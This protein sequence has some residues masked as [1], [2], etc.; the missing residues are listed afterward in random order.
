[1]DE[2]SKKKI[3]PLWFI[4]PLSIIA[5]GFLCYVP[6]WINSAYLKGGEYQTVWNGSEF[7]AFY[8][9][10]L[11]ALGA[12]FL[13]ALSIWQNKQMQKTNEEAQKRLEDINKNANEITIINKFVERENR[14]IENLSKACDNFARLCL[15]T[16]VAK[17][18]SENKDLDYSISQ[19]RIQI[20]NEHQC[21]GRE[22]SVDLLNQKNGVELLAKA[23][24]LYDENNKFFERLLSEGESILDDENAYND[25]S[26]SYSEFIII[27]DDY[28]VAAQENINSVLLGEI[29]LSELRLTHH[30]GME[31]KNG[32]DEDAE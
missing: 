32:Q 31:V 25:L 4:V 29:S 17:L 28:L 24:A 2:R 22:M 20:F 19:I 8:G 26:V 16:D 15:L 10:L 9:S 23:T 30:Y 18:V 3:S 7:L 5:F 11:S 21:I 13:G 6:F 14:R 12:L 27:K 1:M